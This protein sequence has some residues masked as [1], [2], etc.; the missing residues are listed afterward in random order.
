MLWASIFGGAGEAMREGEGDS[1]DL[2]LGKLAVP[3]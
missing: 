1:V 3:G 2:F